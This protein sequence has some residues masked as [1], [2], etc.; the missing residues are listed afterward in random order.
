MTNIDWNKQTWDDPARWESEWK[1]GYAWGNVQ[2]V[3]RDFSRLVAPYM[4]FGRKPV[5]L[6]IACGMGRFTELLLEVAE[7]VHSIDL[8]KHCVES[9][10]ARFAGKP[11]KAEL[12]DGKTLPKGEFD[13]VV[14]YDSLVHA[15]FDVVAAY[16]RQ[17]RDVLVP[18]GHVC[19]HHANRP[20][21][22]SSR[23]DVRSEQVFGLI[24]EMPGMRLNSQ[25]LF[26][27]TDGHFIDCFTVAQR[28][29][30]DAKP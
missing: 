28:L 22:N 9:C 18:G 17:A 10:R 12:T 26:R 29:P 30:N 5:I 19:I 24:M 2:V 20:D 8:A 4:P 3:R 7:F 6:E 27:L 14:S 25:S 13:M 21:V 1:G 15:D 16:F 23:M 11:F